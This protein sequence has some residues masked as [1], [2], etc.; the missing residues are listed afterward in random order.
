MDRTNDSNDQQEPTTRV[1]FRKWNN[2]DII[3]LFPQVPGGVSDDTC[4]SYEHV[5]QHGSADYFSVVTRTRP[6][7]DAEA[8]DLKAELESIGYVLDVKRKAS[9]A[10][11]TER[12]EA[13]RRPLAQGLL[14][15][16]VTKGAK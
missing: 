10:D 8:A 6:A 3:A 9:Y 2:G 11:H 16:V 12:R 1:V 14:S 4:N 7:T 13:K 15:N 5:G